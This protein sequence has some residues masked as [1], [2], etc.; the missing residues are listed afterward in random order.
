MSIRDLEVSQQPM[1]VQMLK[2]RMIEVVQKLEDGTP[3]LVEAMLDIHTNTHQHEELVSLLS[4]EDIA[5]LHKAHE[6]H[7]QIVLIQKETKQAKKS[8]K[9]TAEDLANL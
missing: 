3:G 2:A 1:Q 6:K 8:K 7:K 9:L 4:D 5:A